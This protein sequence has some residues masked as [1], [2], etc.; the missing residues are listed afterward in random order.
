MEDLKRAARV[1]G[2]VRAISLAS[3]STSLRK[4]GNEFAAR[5][6]DG[7]PRLENLTGSI[8]AIVDAGAG[9][10]IEVILR[11][12]NAVDEEEMRL[13]GRYRASAKL[14]GP[15]DRKV[16]E[17]EPSVFGF[18]D[19][20]EAA[21]SFQQIR[22]YFVA[23]AVE[24]GAVNDPVGDQADPDVIADDLMSR[25]RPAFDALEGRIIGEEALFEIGLG[26]F[27][28]YVGNFFTLEVDFDYS[29]SALT[30]Q[31][32]TEFILG[33]RR[34]FHTGTKVEVRMHEAHRNG[35]MWAA[36]FTE[37]S[38][39]VRE[40]EP[41]GSSYTTNCSTGDRMYD[42]VYDA[43]CN[44]VKPGDKDAAHERG[45]VARD[46]FNRIGP[47]IE[48]FEERDAEQLVRARQ[49]NAE[50]QQRQVRRQAKG[51]DRLGYALRLKK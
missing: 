36:E 33:K 7:K 41:D 14:M 29:K 19:H 44:F 1:S 31:P 42:A 39:R 4:F 3:Y 25:F 5:E 9:R 34:W 16:L 24:A 46:L 6:K 48:Q 40:T 12:E 2:P 49:E 50:W 20:A 22:D 51:L 17:D 28:D 38:W 18:A 43:S 26:P 47:A 27:Q 13:Y 8:S 37:G 23:A 30:F 32:I 21:G 15:V 10:R 35:A 45:V 11:R